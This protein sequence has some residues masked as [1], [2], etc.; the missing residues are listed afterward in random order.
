MSH[1]NPSFAQPA[2]PPQKSTLTV[3]AWLSPIVG[4]F[5]PAIVFVSAAAFF[6]ISS[7]PVRIIL[8]VIVA[9]IAI[10]GVTLSIIL[11]IKKVRPVVASILGI[12]LN[13][14]PLALVV[15]LA[16][17]VTV[18][19]PEPVAPYNGGSPYT[20]TED[21]LYS[22]GDTVTDEGGIVFT[23]DSAE[24]VSE[25]ISADGGATPGD[26]LK[27]VYTV[28]NDSDEEL[29]LTLVDA[30]AISTE[31]ETQ[32][33]AEAEV[34]NIDGEP[35]NTSLPIGDTSVVTSY[36]RLGDDPIDGIMLDLAWGYDIPTFF[37]IDSVTAR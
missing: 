20:Q 8:W 26:W 22:V 4:F 18:A 12:I 7:F 11:L 31:A 37:Q 34:G 27:V 16:V 3:L 36:F 33:E 14:I 19:R 9:V 24:T 2:S 25:A 17:V 28:T 30:F 10:L 23:L 1:D 13:L 6:A 15:V 29:S 35:Y 21:S 5:L 32:S